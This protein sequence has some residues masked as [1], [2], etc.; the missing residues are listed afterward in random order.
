M[1]LCNDSPLGEKNGTR[2]RVLF[3]AAIT[4]SLNAIVNNDK[5]IV[6]SDYSYSLMINVFIK[7]D[8]MGQYL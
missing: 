8:V 5:C 4:F 3:L 7:K 1:S 6:L 2:L